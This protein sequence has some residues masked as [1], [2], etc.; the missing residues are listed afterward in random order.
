MVLRAEWK[1]I[2]TAVKNH[3]KMQVT[4][5]AR[6]VNSKNEALAAQCVSILQL[7]DDPW[8]SQVLKDIFQDKPLNDEEGNFYP[9]LWSP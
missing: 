6:S 2:A 3:L 8:G 7:L 4:Q 9:F 5:G 1:S